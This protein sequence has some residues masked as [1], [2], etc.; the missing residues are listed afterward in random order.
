VPA[1]VYWCDGFCAVDVPPSPNVQLQLVGLFVDSS[2]KFTVNGASPEV[3]LPL[4]AATGGGGTV[5][6]M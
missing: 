3:G 4:K 2:V 5:T 1:E 6:V